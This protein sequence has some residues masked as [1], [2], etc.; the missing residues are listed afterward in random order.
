MRKHNPTVAAFPNSFPYEYGEFEVEREVDVPFLEHA[1]WAIRHCGGR[2]AERG[3]WPFYATP[4]NQRNGSDGVG[5]AS[6]PT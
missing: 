4:T 3:M 2:F 6:D 5:A 1:R